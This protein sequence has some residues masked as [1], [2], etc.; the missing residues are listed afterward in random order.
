LFDP[1]HARTISKER[2][3]IHPYTLTEGLLTA[4]YPSM[5]QLITR[6]NGKYPYLPTE[7]LHGLYDGAHGAGLADYWEA[8]RQSPKGA[9]GVLWCWSDA[10]IARTDLD[11]K[12]DTFGNKAPDGIVGP[13]GE[14]EASY[15]TVREIWSPVQIPFE[16][17]PAGF[18]GTFPV[19]NRYDF[20]P[21]SKCSFQWR[22]LGFSGPRSATTEI[23]VLGFKARNTAFGKTTTTIR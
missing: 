11:G 21:L 1:V 7:M 8:I 20:T 16:K 12:L 13:N 4:H 22:L 3:V 19:E 17:L 2:T 9:G 18:N 6:L 15:Y 5:E 10:A 14:K 23:R